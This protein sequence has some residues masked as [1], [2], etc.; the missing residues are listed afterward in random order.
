M[1]LYTRVVDPL[2]DL[3]QH[4]ATA[5][6]LPLLLMLFVFGPNCGLSLVRIS[7]DTSALTMRYLL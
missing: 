6:L 7:G 3:R 2:I 4:L 5:H 1:N